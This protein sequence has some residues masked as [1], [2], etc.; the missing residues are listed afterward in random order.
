LT[1][2]EGRLA[3]LVK[4]E[5]RTPRCLFP[6]S[7]EG[8]PYEKGSIAFAVWAWHDLGY[9]G[10]GAGHS[11]ASQSA[12]AIFDFDYATVHGG[13][14]RFWETSTSARISDL[15]VKYLVRTAAIP[16]SSAGPMDKILTE[17]N[18][19][20]S[21]RANPNSAPK[22]Q[23]LGVDAIIVG[24]ITRSAMTPRKRVGR[25][26]RRLGGLA[27]W[28][29]STPYEAIVA[30]DA[31][32]VDIDTAEFWPSPKAKANRQRSSTSLVGEG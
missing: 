26:R 24:S 23:L 21:D 5:G 18:F 12:V 6:E 29:P 28:I 2:S 16:L 27:R 1:V 8:D 22:S 25:S 20:H 11:H 9:S 10:D 4:G 13:V 30:L 32:I 31:R 19:S 7:R 14:A 3:S 17:Q 15:L